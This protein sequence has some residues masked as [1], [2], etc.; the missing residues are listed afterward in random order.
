M[1][2]SA[3]TAWALC[4]FGSLQ[5]AEPPAVAFEPAV[6]ADTTEFG[7]KDLER[8]DF[9]NDGFL[10]VAVLTAGNGG[11]VHFL[12]GGASGG[13]SLDNTLVV[14]YASGIASGDFNGDGVRDLAVTQGSKV[15]GTPDGLCDTPTSILPSTI[16]F[17][18]AAAA[19]RRGRARSS[20][21]FIPNSRC[22]M[23]RHPRARREG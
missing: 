22:G 6:V 7:P 20:K 9:N 17:L 3:L 1:L 13:L 14:A 19:G 8:A 16:V 18:G 5:A 21:S 15:N 2:T 23:C 4:G 10:D 11:E 12:L